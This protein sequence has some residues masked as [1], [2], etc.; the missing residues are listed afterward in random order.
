MMRARKKAKKALDALF[1]EIK[2][3]PTDELPALTGAIVDLYKSIINP[4]QMFLL[5]FGTCLALVLAYSII[6]FVI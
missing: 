6:R 4:L 2:T 1:E 5:G 3:A